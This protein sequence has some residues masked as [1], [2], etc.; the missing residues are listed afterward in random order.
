MQH[1]VAVIGEPDHGGIRR[2]RRKIDARPHHR[3]GARRADDVVENDVGA[4]ALT[5]VGADI[6][7]AVDQAEA[8]GLLVAEAGPYEPAGTA[9]PE[10]AIS[11]VTRPVP[12]F[13]VTSRAVTE[14]G[15]VHEVVVLD[16]S[17]Q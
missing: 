6:E 10:S 14:D 7:E 1:S 12:V 3:H 8:V 2:D 15:A 4:E 13:S 9:A 16:L 5:G 17:P 11:A